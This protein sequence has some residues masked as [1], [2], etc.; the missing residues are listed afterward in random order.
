M[1]P[2]FRSVT[3]VV[4]VS[5][6]GASGAALSL[7]SERLGGLP[8]SCGA[9]DQ[10]RSSEVCASALEA[11]P[12][13]PSPI[14]LLALVIEVVAL[15]KASR[16]QVWQ[17]DSHGEPWRGRFIRQSSV[18]SLP[19]DVAAE[20][21]AAIAVVGV[22]PDPGVEREAVEDIAAPGLLERLGVAQPPLH[23]GGLQGGESV[24]LRVQIFIEPDDDLRRP[25][26][27]AG[28]D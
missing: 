9:P 17:S 25:P 24:G 14:S 15:V 10:A 20:P 8:P 13:R 22:D 4:G 7:A 19:R 12:T 2:P 26:H 23:V 11:A 18:P 3:R 21:L 28:E 16:P 6:S 5:P 27:D 1:S